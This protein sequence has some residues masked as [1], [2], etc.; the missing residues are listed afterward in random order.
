[1][2]FVFPHLSDEDITGLFLCVFVRL[3]FYLPVDC[4]SKSH[5]LF[6]RQLEKR[7]QDKRRQD[8][9]REDKTREDNNVRAD[10]WCPTESMIKGK[11]PTLYSYMTKG[12]PLGNARLEI[13]AEATQP[14][15]FS[16]LSEQKYF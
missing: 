4:I 1:M 13:I 5:H 8:K 6:P 14:E 7:R 9:R 2:E 11:G 10:Y 16:I 3:C 12:Y 15:H